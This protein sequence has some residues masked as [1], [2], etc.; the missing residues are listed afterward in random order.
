M[1]SLHISEFYGL[2]GTVQSD[3]IPC[4]DA[5][6]HNTDQVVAIGGSS[7]SS[8]AFANA[9]PS[10]F[11]PTGQAYGSVE[12]PTRWVLLTAGAACS[13]AFGTAPTAVAGGW[14]MASGSQ[15]LVRVPENQTW[16]VAVIADSN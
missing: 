14:F 6:A 9:N 7:I 16:K 2:A 5:G 13:I 1:A 12:Q 10:S 4:V 11:G 3:S 8:N 15:L